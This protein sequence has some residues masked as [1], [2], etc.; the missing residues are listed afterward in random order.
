MGAMD[1]RLEHA[2]ANVS[3]IAAAIEWY[4]TV[5]QQLTPQDSLMLLAKYQDYHSG[6]NFQHYDPAEAHS[7]FTYDEFQEPIAL[8]GY[9]REW[10]PGSH[11]GCTAP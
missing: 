7:N 5:K 4:T 2:R 8:V 6:D 11:T 10:G 9:H 1:T 3:D